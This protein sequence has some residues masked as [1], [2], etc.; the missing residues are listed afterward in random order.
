MSEEV[1][2]AAEE[3]EE[4]SQEGDAGAHVGS[5]SVGATG[6]V[7]GGATQRGCNSGL[8]GSAGSEEG[9]E[10]SGSVESGMASDAAAAAT[11][12]AAGAPC[13]AA[14]SA[15]STSSTSGAATHWPLSVRTQ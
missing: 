13:A 1:L 5:S 14:A 7:C 9:C 15:G 4:A 12:T 3:G 11:T 2:D 8:L 10:V 6:V